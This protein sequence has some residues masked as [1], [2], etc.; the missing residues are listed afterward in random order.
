[1]ETLTDTTRI[2]G[3]FKRLQEQRAL[4]SIKIED[5]P[6]EF[7]TAIINVS[8]EKGTITLDELKPDHGHT[9]LKRSPIF[10]ARTQ[11]EGVT[12]NFTA[13]VVEFGKQDAIDYYTIQIPTQLDYH[14]RRQSVRISLNSAIQFPVTLT[15]ANGLTITGNLADLS[16]GGLRVRFDKDLPLAIEDGQHLDCSFLLPSDNK[17]KFRCEVIVRVIRHHHEGHKA[18][19][20][21]GQFFD[22]TKPQERQIS[23]TVML[24]QRVAQQKRYG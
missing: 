6:H 7:T 20:L 21:G 23:R 14:Q 17:E 19:S 13:T 16:V 10:R 15:T 3:L 11:L 9:L 2:I 22:I 5:H 4:L 1:M 12:I 8:P 24:L 18:P